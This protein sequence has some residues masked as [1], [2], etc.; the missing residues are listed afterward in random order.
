[1]ADI[2]KELAAIMAAV[3]GEEV[4]GSIHDAIAK[5]N[6]VGEA[7]LTIGTAVTDPTSSVAGYFEKS[8]YINANTN[9][10]WVCTGDAWEL[11]GNI[12]GDKGEQGNKWFRGTNVS[13]KSA[14]PKSFNIQ[15]AAGDM[16]VNVTEQSIYHCTEGGNP[17]KWSY[18]F[19]ISSGGGGSVDIDGITITENTAG[20][21]QV[22][23]SITTKLSSLDDN[24]KIDF[25]NVKSTP[26]TLSGYGITNSYTKTEVD[27][28]LDNWYEQTPQATATGDQTVTFTGLDT[29]K[30]YELWFETSNG[31]QVGIKSSSLSGT[32]LSYVVSIP[33]DCPVPVNFKLRVVK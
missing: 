13:G 5:I 26:K 10:L 18:D 12:K 16:Y 30:A 22:A 4:R 24:G 25:S 3:Y 21:I 23:E 17:S 11:K 15:A 31:S 20:E 28:K 27:N 7:T 8:V 19:T 33:S 9:D 32:T 29:S 2:R 6:E 14:T 1:M